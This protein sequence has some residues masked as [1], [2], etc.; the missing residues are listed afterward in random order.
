MVTVTLSQYAEGKSRAEVARKLV[1]SRAAVSM[2]LS[3]DREIYVDVFD[4]EKVVA[5][6][7]RPVPARRHRAA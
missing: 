6:E 3:S 4:S 2:M 5:W 7:K 1:C